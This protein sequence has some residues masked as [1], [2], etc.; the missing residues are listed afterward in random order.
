MKI[1][2]GAHNFAQVLGDSERLPMI[3]INQALQRV[4]GNVGFKQVEDVVHNFSA[5]RD[6]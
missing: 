2:Q 4:D 6:G 1:A 5:A 3:V